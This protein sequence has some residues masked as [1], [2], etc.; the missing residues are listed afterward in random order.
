MQLIYTVPTFLE[1]NSNLSLNE[2]I[3]EGKKGKYE[4]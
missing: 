3:A 4:A 2:G 1:P